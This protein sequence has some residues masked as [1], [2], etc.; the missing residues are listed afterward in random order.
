[1][2]KISFLYLIFS[3]LI[4]TTLSACSSIPLWV[5]LPKNITGSI[6]APWES[7]IPTGAVALKWEFII[8]GIQWKTTFNNGINPDT[9]ILTQKT[10]FKTNH[11]FIHNSTRV[12]FTDTEL[13]PGN[14]FYF[15]GRVNN[16]DDW[17]GHFYYIDY[18]DWKLVEKFEKIKEAEKADIDTLL[19]E[20]SYC[21]KDED[22]TSFYATC[23]FWCAKW[24]NTKYLETAQLLI[25]NYRNTQ[26]TLWNPQ[27]E[28]W[29]VAIQ[30]TKCENYKC[31]VILEN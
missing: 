29:C 14:T 17:A 11:L 28:Y 1:M 15:S 27:C 31:N 16:V 3:F 18:G 5:S 25:D 12:N 10:Q 4:L 26:A 23:P 6:L 21:E 24:I 19:T 13:L 8:D 30:W 7:F 22:C 2:K 9:L 20:Y